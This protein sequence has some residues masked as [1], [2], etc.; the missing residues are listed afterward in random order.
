MTASAQC[1]V[2][3]KESHHGYLCGGHFTGLGSTL[4]QIEEEACH[5]DAR[6]S[7]AV[8][9]DGGHH[10]L[11]SEQSPVRLN[12]LVFRD[13]RTKLWVRDETPRPDL[14]SPKMIGPWCLFC[15]HDTC[16][17]WRAGRQRDQHDDEYDAGSE[18]LVSILGILSGWAQIVREERALSTPDRVTISGERDVLTRHL[19]WIAGQPWVDEMFAEVKKLAAQ[20]KRANGTADLPVGKCTTLYDGYECGGTIRN[21]EIDHHD[22]AIEP[23]FK[24]NRCRRV[25]TGTEAVRLRNALWVEEQQKAAG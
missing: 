11:A 17:T 1:V 4:R 3:S 13:P 18:G 9:L 25:W 22:G 16:T 20:I 23:G 5:L 6:P 14:P 19:D 24:C 10:G 15:D 8:P 21:V 12:I 2:C 7:M